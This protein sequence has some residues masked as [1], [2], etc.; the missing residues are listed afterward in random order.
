MPIDIQMGLTCFIGL[1]IIINNNWK[2]A[3]FAF[4]GKQ[5]SLHELTTHVFEEAINNFG[6][7]RID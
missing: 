6:K 2:R 5:L 4:S 1:V 7:A 3:Y